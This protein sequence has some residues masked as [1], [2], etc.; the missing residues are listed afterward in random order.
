MEK[1]GVM[2]D[3]DLID[4]DSAARRAVGVYL[5]VLSVDWPVV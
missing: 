3:S 4:G 5:P 2:L 1:W